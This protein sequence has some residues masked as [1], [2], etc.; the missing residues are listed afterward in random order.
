MVNLGIKIPPEQLIAAIRA[1]HPDILG[2]SGLLVK[3]AQQMVVTAA[4]LTHAGIS[5][6][7]L[8]GGAALSENF[9][10][11]QIA[12]A[13]SGTVVYAS[14]AMNGLELAKK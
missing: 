13:Y 10:L 11:K 8:V 1:H 7:V 5:L 2:L 3:S 6:P 4:D 9:V 14:D 12:P